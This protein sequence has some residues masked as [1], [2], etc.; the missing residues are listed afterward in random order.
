MKAIAPATVV[1]LTDFINLSFENSVFPNS[2]KCAKVILL[3]KNGSKDCVIN[4]W[5]ISLL[6]V[7]KKFF[8]SAMHSKLYVFF[9]RFSLFYTKQF[10]F[11]KEHSTI[12]AL[13]EFTRKIRHNPSQRA[14]CFFLDLRKTF[15]TLD[16]QILLNKLYNYG[17]RGVRNG[18]FKNY[19]SNRSQYV[20]VRNSTSLKR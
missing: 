5:P 2:L 15:D 19:L 9:E 4:Y 11:R 18:W 3:H 13:A 8:D 12:D 20:E 17:V 1:L 16:F 7:W 6:S 10:G 14:V